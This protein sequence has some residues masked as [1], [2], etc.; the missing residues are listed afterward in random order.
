M[1]LIYKKLEQLEVGKVMS[2]NEDEENKISMSKNILICLCDEIW[3]NLLKSN[4]DLNEF[5]YLKTNFN[6]I[7]LTD[8]SEIRTFDH[9]CIVY[10]CG[11]AIKHLGNSVIDYDIPIYI[12][13]E[14]TLNYENNNNYQ[15][16]NLGKVPI[17][18]HGVGVYFREL[19]NTDRDY[20][21]ELK[22][23]RQFQ[24]LR[25][26]NK[27]VAFR[28]GI[29]KSKVSINPE[30]P[31]V[32][33]FDLLRCSTN[34][35]GPTENFDP[36]DVKIINEVNKVCENVFESR[37]NLNHVLAQIYENHKLNRFWTFVIWIINCIWLFVFGKKYYN[38]TE[39]KAKI[40]AHSDKTKDMPRNGLIAFCTFYEDFSDKNIK[41]SN[42]NDK[43]DCRFKNASVLTTLHFKLKDPKAY[44]HLK[45]EFSVKLYK[46]SMFVIPLSTNR[47]YTHE[48]RPSVLSIEHIPIRLGYVIR[49][50]S[51]KA[52][53]KNGQTYI[54]EGDQY[55]K[56]K[57][58]TENDA[59]ILRQLYFDENTTDKI[60]KYDAVH[61]SM[62]TGDYKKP[63]L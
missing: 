27:S 45:K 58:I 25:E 7:V 51:T 44:P 48:I 61:Y 43:Y 39:K 46:N 8:V 30:N 20:F 37:A 31:D 56:L 55:I 40:K 4:G 41:K 32:L 26:S 53:F 33:E 12:I 35:S 15:E 22:T 5:N 10:L 9:T 49:C 52:V 36:I 59:E 14:F 2:T 63:M 38:I 24:K 57:P 3:E 60:I 28:S 17:N 34:L 13:S 19:F 23:N 11:N 47:K 18:I 50:S 29:Y 16:I 42:K 1:I 6:G 54:K 62:N 21:K